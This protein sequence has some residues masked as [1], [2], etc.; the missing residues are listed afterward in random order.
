MLVEFR[1]VSLPEIGTF[2]LQKNQA[3]FTANR[4]SLA[5]PID[6]CI[7][8]PVPDSDVF[9]QDLMV[10]SGFDAQ[11]SGS[12]QR[13]MVRDIAAGMGDSG[14]YELPQLG[15][16]T[17]NG[18]V[19]EEG[20]N[21]NQY[22]NLPEIPVIP[23]SLHERS[24]YKID[25]AVPTTSHIRE[26]KTATPSLA[27]LIFP[28]LVGIL[29][30]FILVSRWL[31]HIPDTPSHPSIA[32]HDVDT[33]TQIS[34]DTSIGIN[35]MVDSAVWHKD[36]AANALE[37]PSVTLLTAEDAPAINDDTCI[38]YV[39]TFEEEDNVD[40]MIGQIKNKGYEPITERFN[41]LTRVGVKFDCQISNPDSFKEVI[42]TKINKDAWTK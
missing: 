28:L 25:Y 10:E 1:S 31:S 21:F 4:A 9:F 39:G 42:R 24:G 37:E 13:D 2:Y 26:S 8:I 3:H 35:A 17:N 5:P 36:T 34:T 27:W 23:L 41:D 18:F 12:L 19:F 40:K 32:Q 30:A 22:F 20:N 38:V 33:M 16:F 15:V 6:T 11:K 7:F 14:A 29:A